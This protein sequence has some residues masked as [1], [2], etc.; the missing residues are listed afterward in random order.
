MRH[1]LIGQKKILGKKADFPPGFFNNCFF[2]LSLSVCLSVC[3]SLFF[4]QTSPRP[5]RASVYSQA[6]ASHPPPTSIQ[7][8][9]RGPVAS[10]TIDFP[11]H[12]HGITIVGGVDTAYGGLFISHVVPRCNAARAGL[13][14]GDRLLAVDLRSTISSKCSDIL[15]VLT[16]LEGVMQIEVQRLSEKDWIELH[17]ACESFCPRR[18]EY[19]RGISLPLSR[20]MLSHSVGSLAIVELQK[21]ENGG[22]LGFRVIGGSDSP[23]GGLFITNI[24]VKGAAAAS[25]ALAKGYRILEVN[26]VSLLNAG[27]QAA[28][29]YLRDD[30]DVVRLVVQQIESQEWERIQ[31]AVPFRGTVLD[32]LVEHIDFVP[33]IHPAKGT[34]GITLSDFSNNGVFVTEL[35]SGGAAE[36]SGLQVGDFLLSLGYNGL[37]YRSKEECLMILETGRGPNPMLVL[38]QAYS[39]HLTASSRS[40][41]VDRVSCALVLRSGTT[42][43]IVETSGVIFQVHLRSS[44]MSGLGLHLVGGEETP[45]Q[46][47]FVAGIEPNSP[48]AIEGHISVGDRLLEVNGNTVLMVNLDDI[49]AEL[50]QAKVLL[51]LQHLGQGQWEKVQATHIAFHAGN[52]GSEFLDSNVSKGINI[53]LC[54][55]GQG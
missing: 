52:L 34:L 1:R 45:L 40:K 11:R 17:A 18:S 24:A 55:C 13:A 46:G 48:A 28:M 22:A 5:R 43:D 47:L 39:P 42:V 16:S 6:I 36:Q 15:S 14:A 38:R 3:L 49:Q 44:R 37:L 54:A 10:F 33:P 20:G 21:E 53:H 7:S 9:T 29:E 23:F 30:Q 35:E 25:N 41:D 19:L 8:I 26:G 12:G 4:I 31:D 32:G 2:S 50:K 51:V 27:R